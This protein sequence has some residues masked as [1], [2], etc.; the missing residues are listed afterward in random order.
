MAEHNVTQVTKD[1]VMDNIELDVG[2]TKFKGV[3]IAVLFSFAT[4]IGGGIWT[5]S[6]FFSRLEA[7]EEAV[8]NAVMEAKTLTIQFDNLQ[9]KSTADIAAFTSQINRMDQQLTDN[10]VSELQGKLAELKTNLQQI[11]EQQTQLLNVKE[12]VADLDKSVAESNIIVEA[13]GGKF[14]SYDKAVKKMQ[15]EAD[16]LWK[17]MDALANPLGN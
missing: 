10:G 9:T 2:G 8:S 1:I 17:A 5:A 4:T 16:D 14:E 15:R 3:W 7:Q 11:L 12:K 6:E 13:A